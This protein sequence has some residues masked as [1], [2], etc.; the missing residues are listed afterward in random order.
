[1]VFY[2]NLR[3]MKFKLGN[4]DLLFEGFVFV[5]DDDKLLMSCELFDSIKIDF[6]LI[7]FICLVS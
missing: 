3:D 1:M 5:F 6:D 7:C 2:I 4:E